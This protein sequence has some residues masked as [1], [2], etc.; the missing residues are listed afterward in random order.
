[1]VCA[2]CRKSAE[3]QLRCDFV[4]RPWEES[5]S[6]FANSPSLCALSL[7][8]SGTTS[9]ALRADSSSGT[10]EQRW[11]V[12][13]EV[14]ESLA[15]CSNGVSDGAQHMESL[16]P[17]ALMHPCSAHRNSVLGS[18][19]EVSSSCLYCSEGQEFLVPSR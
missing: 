5:R 3:L 4:S 13:T 16:I 6:L 2:L 1:M 18:L 9:V 15:G 7:V 11:A 8:A 12:S 10:S 19:C 14:S 17:A